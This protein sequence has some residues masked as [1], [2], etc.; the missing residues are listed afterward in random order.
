M[1]LEKS[2][3]LTFSDGESN[4]HNKP[5]MPLYLNLERKKRNMKIAISPTDRCRPNGHQPMQNAKQGRRMGS[6]AGALAPG[7]PFLGAT[8]IKPSNC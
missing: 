1:N 5:T 2:K 3:Q 4:K 7:R 8:K 6:A